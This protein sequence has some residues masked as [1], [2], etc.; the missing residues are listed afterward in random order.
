M[1]TFKT[2]HLILIVILSISSA[3]GQDKNSAESLLKIA[4]DYKNKSLPDSA[5][6][7]YE[8]SAIEFNKN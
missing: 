4:D 3:N 7:Y 2:T 8:K 6:I 1:A 5:I